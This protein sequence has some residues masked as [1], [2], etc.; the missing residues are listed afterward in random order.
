MVIRNQAELEEA[1]REI[2]T[3]ESKEASVKAR[4]DLAIAKAKE[5]GRKELAAVHIDEDG[6]AISAE[7]RKAQLFDAMEHHFTKR[8]D[9]YL[10]GDAK[11]VKLTHGTVG[12][13]QSP[14]KLVAVD[15]DEKGWLA[16]LTKKVQPA[17]ETAL[18]G[19]ELA[20]RITGLSALSIKITYDRIGLLNQFKK[21]AFTEGA[22]KRIGLEV[23]GGEDEFFAKAN[24]QPISAASSS[25]A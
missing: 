23:E 15:E 6:E 4:V 22:L 12:F 7:D 25:A 1:L 10:K 16:R 14:L 24:E 3:I 2:G 11:S 21:G 18:K 19:I 5:D 8:A 17:L 20:T 13:R 9:D